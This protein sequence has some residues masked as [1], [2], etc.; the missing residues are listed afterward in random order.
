MSFR[1]P[2]AYINWGNGCDVGLVDWAIGWNCVYLR[3]DGMKKIAGTCVVTSNLSYNM[4]GFVIR[5]SLR[6][7]HHLEW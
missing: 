3:V 7:I 6:S 4:V 5:R 2:K 1:G